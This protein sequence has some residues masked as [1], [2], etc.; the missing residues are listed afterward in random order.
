MD[1]SEWP[2]TVRSR[3]VVREPPRPPSVQQ[4]AQG[5]R[6]PGPQRGGG[7]QEGQGAAAAVYVVK[8]GDTLAR[9]AKAHGTT[10]EEIAKAN[11]LADPDRLKVGQ[12]LLIPKK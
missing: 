3:G 5:A 9:I 4:Q 11:N 2:E 7:G 6:P 10:A 8:S 1:A 12:K